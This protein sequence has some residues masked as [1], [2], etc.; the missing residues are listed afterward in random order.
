MPRFSTKTFVTASVPA[1]GSLN[2]N[3]VIGDSFFDVHKIKIVPSIVGGTSEAQIYEKDTFLVADLIW[4]TNPFAATAF[5][6]VQK[7][8][9]GVETEAQRGFIIPYEDQ[10]ATTELHIKLINNDGQA[11]TYTVTIE[12]E[13]VPPSPVVNIDD[14]SDVVITA[15]ASGELLKFDGANWINN[16]LAEAGAAAASHVHSAADITSGVLAIAQGG[17]ATGSTPTNGQ[18]LIG[19]GTGYALSTLTVVANELDIVNAAGSITLGLPNTVQITTALG[20]G[21]APATS[22]G[23]ELSSTVKAVLLS[24]MTTTQRNALTAVNGM[25]IYNSTLAELQAR[26]GGAWIDLGLTGNVD[27]PGTPLNNQVAVW[28]DGNTIEGDANLTWNSTVFNITGALTVSGTVTFTTD[29][30]I[31]HGGTAGS[32]ASAARTN[33]GLTIGTNVQ[34]W[35]AQLDD[36]AGLAVTDGNL[37]VGNGTNWIAESGAILRTSLGLGTGSAVA[38]A[39]LTLTTDLA[40]AQG[41]TGASTAAA[42]RTNLGLVISTDVQA[43]DAQ[44]DDLAGLAV[45]DSNFI[46]GNG[47][48][49]IVETGATVRTSLGLGSSSAVS[50]GSLTLTTDLAVAQGGT[51]VSSFTNGG[52]LLGSGSG[53]ITALGVAANGQIPIGDGAGD[54]VLAV[55]LGTSNEVEITNGAGSI[56]IGLPSTVQITTALGVGGA[57]AAS[58]GIELAGTTKSLLVSRMNTTQRNALTAVDGMI[59][60][61]TTDLEVQG[62]VNAAWINLGLGGAGF[63]DIS[64]TPANNQLAIWTDADTIEGDPNI[65]WDGSLLNITGSLDVSGSISGESDESTSMALVLS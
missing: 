44:L 36:I 54:P 64:G 62:R 23:I 61:N 63:V 2:H 3:E 49:W 8:S 32:T 1:S 35:D 15:V 10:D 42:A 14:L 43:W 60:Y 41:G 29:L 27:L 13:V 38:F 50:F 7:D 45:A 22:A 58:A 21:G 24:R 52:I 26:A 51:G 37:I 55:I 30:A 17:T 4:G 40:V 20:V 12:Y 11:K 59:I 65:T 28:V 56:Q 18:L 47:T 5:D 39:S 16:T 48:N 31:A 33:L 19:N 34:A 6:P 46:V 53:A 57:P 25:I 9:A